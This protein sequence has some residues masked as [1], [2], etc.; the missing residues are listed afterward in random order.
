[1]TEAE[2]GAVANILVVSA[3]ETAPYLTTLV[4]P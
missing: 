4:Q 3:S 2:K 1:M